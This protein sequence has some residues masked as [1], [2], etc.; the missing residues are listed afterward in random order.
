MDY[1]IEM[2]WILMDDISR[3]GNNSFWYSRRFVLVSRRDLNPASCVFMQVYES[4][5]SKLEILSGAIIS[6]PS[7]LCSMNDDGDDNGCCWDNLL[8]KKNGHLGHI[9]TYPI[10][11]YGAASRLEFRYVEIPRY[12][13]ARL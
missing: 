5:V 4:R 9:A 12:V 13:V 3:G 2:S 1:Q 11:R 7:E 8:L 6:V 10:W